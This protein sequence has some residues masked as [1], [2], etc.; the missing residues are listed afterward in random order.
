[1]FE[2]PARSAGFLSLVSYSVNDG[3]WIKLVVLKL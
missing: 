2:S 1:M 3:Y